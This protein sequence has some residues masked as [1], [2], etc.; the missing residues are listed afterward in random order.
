MM[1]QLKNKMKR[2]PYRGSP[3][4]TRLYSINLP[5]DTIMTTM[6]LSKPITTH[7]RRKAKQKT[8]TTAHQGLLQQWTIL[9]QAMSQL[10]YKT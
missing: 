4:I 7:L 3:L 6:D 5:K 8:K 1:I 2:N 9:Q 10:E